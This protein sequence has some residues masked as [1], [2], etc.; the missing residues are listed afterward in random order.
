MKTETQGANTMAGN[1]ENGGG[2]PASRLRIAAWTAAGLLLLLPLVAMQFT[3]EVN[4]SLSDFVIFG[5]M[6]A[7]VGIAF[8]VAAR[9]TSN[10]AYLSAAG[11]A[12]LGAFLL[13]WSN[14]AVGIIGN[15]GNDANLMYF[16]VLAV[17][18]VGALIARLKPA[19]MAFTMIAMTFALVLVAIIALIAGLDPSGDVLPRGI[20][21][22][23]GIFGVMWAGAAWLF[24][25]A[26]REVASARGGAER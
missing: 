24:W 2:R 12:L 26:A 5:F 9:T 23:T 6:L 1:P 7:S 14:L 18:F 21:L 20:V 19:G 8:E 4:W 15:E 25:I 13:V 11:L 16:G 3:D 17:G 10:T 22:A